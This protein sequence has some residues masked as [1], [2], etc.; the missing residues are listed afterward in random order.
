MVF[1]FD[2]NFSGTIC[3][4]LVPVAPEG[5]SLLAKGVKGHK[6]RIRSG[7][8]MNESSAVCLTYSNH[9]G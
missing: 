3:P 8:T 1:S 4:A 5:V 2:D 6:N 9:R 7:N